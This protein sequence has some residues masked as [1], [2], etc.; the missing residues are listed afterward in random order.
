MTNIE[1]PFGSTTSDDAVLLLAAAEKLG[2]DQ[3]VVATK[4]GAFVVPEEVA[5]EAKLKG[6]EVDESGVVDTNAKAAPKPAKKTAAKK[7]AA[8]KK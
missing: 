8:K 4:T 7:A 1:I 2:L 3:S 6:E 5:K